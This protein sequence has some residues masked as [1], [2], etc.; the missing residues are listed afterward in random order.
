MKQQVDR[1]IA[2]SLLDQ[3]EVYLPNVGTLILRRHAA[4]L[5]SKKQ[6]Q[7][8]Y[9]ELQLTKEQRGATIT[10][11]ISQAA[12]V[13]PERANDIYA[14]WLE[15]SLRN[16]ILTIERVCV[17]EKG[18]ITTDKVFE[19]MANPNGRRVVKINPRTN[20]FIY[21]IAGMCMC[22]AL[23]VAGYVLH[24]NGTINK[25]IAMC[26]I[27]PASEAFTGSY[28]ILVEEEKPAEQIVAPTEPTTE[29]E[30]QAI[31]TTEATTGATATTEATTGATATPE[32]A[33]AETTKAT[34]ESNSSVATEPICELTK[35]RSYA[36]WGVY[37]NLKNAKRYLIWLA[38]NH[39]DIKAEI[40]NYDSRYM[41]A[42]CETKSRNACSSK[43]AEWKKQ[44]KS[45]KDVWVYTR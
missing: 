9:R 39:P 20:Y 25:L 41:I 30:T 35:G 21:I 17:I 15:Q 28:D 13:S 33:T 16:N 6:L 44:H 37:S 19:D 12:G 4:K 23:G 24:T 2:N 11:Y 10:A 8:P 29:V 14:E 40:Y 27:A 31:A 3:G 43:V 34:T 1:L 42:L 45:F 7:Q 18:N 36:V 22:F 32:V 5:L 38:E 26:R